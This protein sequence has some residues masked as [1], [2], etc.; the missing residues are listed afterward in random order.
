MTIRH[1]DHGEHVARITQTDSGWHLVWDYNLIAESVHDTAF[2]AV[3][4]ADEEQRPVAVGFPFE[5]QPARECPL[6][7]QLGAGLGEHRLARWRQH[8][9][10]C[11]PRRRRAHPGPGSVPPAM[12]PV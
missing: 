11:V 10:R 2:A 12:M 5:G 7:R 3:A 6:G 1:H 4:A 9:P 8:I